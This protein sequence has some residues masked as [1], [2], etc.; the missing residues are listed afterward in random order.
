M[1]QETIS[2]SILREQKNVVATK[3][4]FF[5]NINNFKILVILRKQDVLK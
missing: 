5:I 4:T 1:T 3:I 2:N